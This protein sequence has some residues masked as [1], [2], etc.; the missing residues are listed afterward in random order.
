MGVTI[1][2]TF[3]MSVAKITISIESDL[4]KK[5]D[6]LVKER[7]FSNRSQAMQSAVADTISRVEKNRLAH[8]CAKLDKF[9]ERAL[10]D[11]DLDS[12]AAL[13]PEY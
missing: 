7:V 10:A 2:N 8:E 3:V 11:M 13:W 12:E 5:V 4:L 6:R 1:G 9:E